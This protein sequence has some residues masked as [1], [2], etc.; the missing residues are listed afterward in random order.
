MSPAAHMQELLFGAHLETELLGKYVNVHLQKIMPEVFSRVVAASYTA[1]SKVAEI[2]W[3]HSLSHTIL[4]IPFM[5]VL[6]QWVLNSISLCL[7]AI[8]AFPSVKC[9]FGSY[10][11]ISIVFFMLFKIV[12]SMF[13]CHDTHP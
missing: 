2:L 13:F 6:I 10:I 8:F 12:L 3:I 1:T 11:Q 4:L 5:F 7:L 9:Q